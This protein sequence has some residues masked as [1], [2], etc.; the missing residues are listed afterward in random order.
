MEHLELVNDM[1]TRVNRNFSVDSD[2]STMIG[3]VQRNEKKSGSRE[4]S[5]LESLDRRSV[6]ES[7]SSIKKNFSESRLLSDD[8][9]SS[10]LNGYSSKISKSND[11]DFLLYDE[12]EDAPAK[13]ILKIKNKLKKNKTSSINYYLY[14]SLFILF[15]LLNSYY[16]INLFNSYKLSYY[17][18]L[19]IRA[20]IFVASYH[21]IK[22]M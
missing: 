15:I 22:N 18:S 5:G 13:K 21:Y 6:N 2:L 1:Y 16:I 11:L 14:I 9:Y 10:S 7:R 4:Q 19:I 8:N 17:Y 3:S 20:I 12:I